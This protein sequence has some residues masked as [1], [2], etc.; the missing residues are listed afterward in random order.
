VSEILQSLL[1]DLFTDELLVLL[2]NHQRRSDLQNKQV[3]LAQF[4]MVCKGIQSMM[5][6]CNLF[7]HFNNSIDF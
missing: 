2:V 5:I 3:V 7:M 6:S 1:R 4:T